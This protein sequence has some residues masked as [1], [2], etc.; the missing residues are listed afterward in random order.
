MV[1]C[2]SYDTVALLEK[3]IDGV[4]LAVSVLD[5][6]SGPRALP[7][8]EID[9]L[10]GTFDYTARYTAGETE[11]HAPARLSAEV[12]AAAAKAAVVAHR[13]LGLRDLSRTDLIVDSEGVLHYLETNVAP[14]MTA[15]SLLPMAAAA[16]GLDL[17]LMCR[18]L[19]QHSATRGRSEPGSPL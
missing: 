19:L 14:G 11:Y 9:A 12:A 7:A 4:E 13:T 6:G 5:D 17:G 15:T 2:Y 18:D 16:A 3:Y 8:V 1:G 10:S